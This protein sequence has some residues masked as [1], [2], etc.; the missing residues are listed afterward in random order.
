MSSQFRERAL[1]A[2]AGVLNKTLGRIP[3][4]PLQVV[5]D[6]S[7]PLLLYFNF[8][9]EKIQSLVGAEQVSTLNKH[10][11]ELTST[12]A[13]SSNYG[14]QWKSLQT[15][16]FITPA[17]SSR[18]LVQTLPNAAAA[19]GE[20]HGLAEN[21]S[22]FD[23]II[24]P[25]DI[26]ISVPSSGLVGWLTSRLIANQP[27]STSN[28]SRTNSFLL[29]VEQSGSFWSGNAHYTNIDDQ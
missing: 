8:S 16:L 9:Y 15:Q 14:P 10:L 26:F 17:V 18:L 4:A 5:K 22:N 12:I 1:L 20:S 11:R 13:P 23:S 6:L 29:I 28:V 7:T 25:I 19:I 24:P 27:L 2:T 21:I 3:A